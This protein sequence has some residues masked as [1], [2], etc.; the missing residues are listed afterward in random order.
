[1][2]AWITL[3]S[4]FSVGVFLEIYLSESMW[5]RNKWY[6]TAINLIVGVRWGYE[7]MNMAPE[8]SSNKD[9]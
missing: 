5:G 7:A 4:I 9:N 6:L 8:L 2:S 3:P 1:M